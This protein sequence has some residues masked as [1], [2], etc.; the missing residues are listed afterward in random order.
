MLAD[1]PNKQSTKLTKQ[2]VNLFE[3]FAADTG[4]FRRTLFT[5]VDTNEQA[6]AG[7]AHNIRKYDLTDQA[8]QANLRKIP[9]QHVF[10]KVTQEITLLPQQSD[11]TKLFLKRPQI[12]CLLEEFGG[13]I[14]PQML[15][16]EVQVL[17]ILARHPHPNIVPYHGCVVK[18][19]YI[20][21]I[22]LTRYRKFLEHRFCDDDDDDDDDASDL[23]L[24]RFECQCRDAI[25]HIHSLGLAHNDLNPSNIAL[26]DHDN[27]VIL[28]WGSCKEFGG[29]LLSAGT[30][31]WIEDD[32]DVSKKD[33][34]LSALGR[35]MAWMK[36]EKAK[37][38]KHRDESSESASAA[39][40]P[41]AE[42][43]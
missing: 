2:D 21:G 20:T 29:L 15:F 32:Y 31:G 30:P 23:D 8:L 13:S 5:Y 26:D 9:D 41:T 12:H 39:T 34:D 18:R 27:P 7:E 17:E 28:D 38:T 33:H 22:A 11:V 4:A 40:Q 19:G 24:G 42:L 25:D 1:A 36:A 6:W 35:I 43:M 14:V 16:E 10:P 37:R 3:V